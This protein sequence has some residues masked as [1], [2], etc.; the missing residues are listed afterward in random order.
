QVLKV[1]AE[2]ADALDK[3]HRQGVVH[4]D[5][6]PGNIMLTKS[7]AKLL[8]FGLAKP[9]AGALV[10]R[11]A[12]TEAVTAASPM[13]P[14]SPVTAAGTIVGTFQYMSPEQLEGKEA[15]ARSDIFALGAVL[16]EMATGRR[17]FEGK[18]QLSVASAILEKEPEPLSALQPSAPS[19]LDRI[20]RNCLAKDPEARYQSAHDVK[21]QL[22]W[23]REGGMSSATLVPV[24]AGRRWKIRE[25]A[26]WAL[27]ALFLTAA[28]ALAAG[29]WQRLPRPTQ[30]LRFALP[31]TIVARSVAISPDGSQVAL[32]AP[33]EETGRTVIWLNH[34][35]SL[36]VAPIPQTEGAA[37]PFWSPDGQ[38]IGFFADNRL[39]KL[40]LRD[41]SVQSLASAPSGRGGSWSRR[42]IIV[43]APDAGGPLW[44]VA[45][46]GGQPQLVA[47]LPE[48]V[49]SH[50]WP[51][52]LPDGIHY[53]YL[54]ATFTN[55]DNPL[56]AIY[57]G[58]LDSSERKRLV[59]AVSNPKYSPSGHLLLVRD[60]QLIALPFDA[61]SGE[62]GTEAARLAEGV[63]YSTAIYLGSFAVAE[64]GSL[65]YLS[66]T[67]LSLSQFTWMDRSGRELGTVGQVQS[68]N[69][70][71][72]SP[73]G[74][75]L[76]FDASDPDTSNVDV[77][78][79]DLKRNVSRRMTFD[80]GEEAGGAWSPDGQKFVFRSSGEAALWTMAAGGLE[81]AEPVAR[82]GGGVDLLSNSWLP[83]GNIVTSVQ[84]PTKGN[85]L[86]TISVRDH[87]MHTL[88]AGPGSRTNGQIS[89]DRKWIA[90]MSNESGNWEVYVTRYP[91]MQGKVQISSGGG[92]DPHW[93]R[94][95]KEIFYVD[96]K[97][98]LFAVPVNAGLTL[99]I[100]TPTRLFTT[101]GREP[102]SST[103]LYTYDVMADGQRFLVN[104]NA[105]PA[106]PSPVYVVLN[107]TM[108]LRK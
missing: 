19:S 68:Q 91:E 78:I 93:R 57:L 108:A 100:G 92:N 29:Y 97:N 105:K 74:G 54:Q 79:Y 36:E 88:L 102:V 1:G 46:S 16:Y 76:L 37:H 99:E 5:L 23:V 28:V 12:F 50:R 65:V 86:A 26:A 66:G 33:N 98:T 6:K 47:P 9:A 67:E 22:Q 80:P 94:D 95:G 64:N 83:D 11:T 45:E 106:N 41:G 104:R 21:L 70:P 17:A 89:P 25:R 35:G 43:Y 56:D 72:L 15:D 62:V 103:D 4:R 61:R 2:I 42:G 31:L 87:S 39:K 71:R 81:K 96:R 63:Q 69:N 3:A 53:L 7:G 44:R 34:V 90:Y 107:W 60:R 49:A 101:R 51:E 32:V 77:Y 27:A 48:G 75:K 10:G 8:D 58:S 24:T 18:S 84:D 59:Q 38:F 40:T 52:F 82:A 20:V 85:Y 13:S 14:T 55:A 73:D 30:A